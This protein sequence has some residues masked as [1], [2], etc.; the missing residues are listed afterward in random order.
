MSEDVREDDGCSPEAE[1]LLPLDFQAH[2]LMN[3]EAWHEYALFVL[4][5]ND[6]AENAVHRAFLEILRHWDGLLG[7]SDLQQQTWA[8]LRRVVIDELLGDFRDRLAEMDSG[9][10]LYPALGKLTQS[11]FDVIVLRYIAKY[12]T[13]HISWY[14]GVTA[15]TVDYHCRKARERLAPVYRRRYGMKKEDAK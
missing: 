3:Q 14:L 6:A 12:D 7:E 8:I 4:R 5:T 11:Q 2:Y 10:G 15:S 9:I 13:K 1:A